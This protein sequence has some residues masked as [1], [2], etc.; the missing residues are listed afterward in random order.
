MSDYEFFKT[1]DLTFFFLLYLATISALICVGLS[2]PFAITALVNSFIPLAFLFV[3]FF[4]YA[5]I[6]I[7]EAKLLE[8]NSF[9]KETEA[10]QNKNLDAFFKAAE[11][12]SSV[13]SSSFAPEVASWAWLPYLGAGVSVLVL[14]GLGIW[15]FYSK[16]DAGD[17]PS[18]VDIINIVFDK[19]IYVK[20]AEEIPPRRDPSE[21]IFSTDQ[22]KVADKVTASIFENVFADEIHLSQSQGGSLDEVLEQVGPGFLKVLGCRENLDS[23]FSKVWRSTN[24]QGLSPSELKAYKIIQGLSEL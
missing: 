17:L 15:H 19:K 16:K 13:Y 5:E 14:V 1:L 4:A 12:A 22:E 3:V 24:G 18:F 23:Q 6:L 21:F 9:I 11:D 20:A 8:G 2:F 10:L 7:L